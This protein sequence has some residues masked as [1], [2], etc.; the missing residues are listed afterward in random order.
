MPAPAPSFAPPPAEAQEETPPPSLR[1]LEGFRHDPGFRN[2]MDKARRPPGAVG[3]PRTQRP[4]D[5]RP[6]GPP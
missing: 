2:F 3:R 4:G 5:G 1:S 6:F